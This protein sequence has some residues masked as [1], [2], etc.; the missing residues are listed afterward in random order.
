MR[1]NYIYSLLVLSSSTCRCVPALYSCHSCPLLAGSCSLVG[2]KC[3]GAC[4]RYSTPFQIK[5]YMVNSDYDQT[6]ENVASDTHRSGER[7]I[8]RFDDGNRTVR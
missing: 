2:T 1:K 7:R 3:M 4:P 5:K 6:A 8:K